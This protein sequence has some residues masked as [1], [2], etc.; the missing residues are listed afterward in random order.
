MRVFKRWSRRVGLALWELPQNVLGAGN[1]IA[2][3][4]S[5]KIRRIRFERE[6]VM[7]EVANGT[8]VSL[9]LFVFWNV[10]FIV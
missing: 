3:L 9:G 10:V 7:I 2:M 1:A 5:G 4:V 8:A 6:R